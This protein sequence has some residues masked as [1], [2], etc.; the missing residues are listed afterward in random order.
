MKCKTVQDEDVGDVSTLTECADKA[1]EIIMLLEDRFMGIAG[2]HSEKFRHEY[3]NAF[4]TSLWTNKSTF[5][6]IC[7]LCL[8]PM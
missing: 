7:A 5:L 8:L 6:S 4:A 1:V 2:W 3:Q